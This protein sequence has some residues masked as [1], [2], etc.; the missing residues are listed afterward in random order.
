VIFKSLRSCELPPVARHHE[1]FLDGVPTKVPTV[2]EGSYHRLMADPS[3]E[4]LLID[5]V[6]NK[7]VTA[8]NIADGEWGRSR[9]DEQRGREWLRLKYFGNLHGDPLEAVK[10]ARGGLQQSLMASRSGTFEETQQ[11]SPFSRAAQRN[12][13]TLLHAW[14]NEGE[15]G[16]ARVRA[17]VFAPGWET[18]RSAEDPIRVVGDTG[19]CEE[20]AL[21]VR[22]AP[23]SET[24]VAAEW[25]YLYHTLGRSWKPEMHSTRSGKEEG[26]HFS[27]HDILVLPDSHRS[28][29]FRLPW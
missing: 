1:A 18:A 14:V 5:L 24:R 7:H 2:G 8:W 22:G 23:D 20:R 17:E 25:W 12:M 27:V 13:D 4:Q 6:M 26:V 16:F 21:E 28:V 3:A 19:D 9:L 10:V 11:Q 29:F 15:T